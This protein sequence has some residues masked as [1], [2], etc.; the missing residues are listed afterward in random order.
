MTAKVAPPLWL[1]AFYDTTCQLKSRYGVVLLALDDLVN[2]GD[3]RLVVTLVDDQSQIRI[4]QGPYLQAQISLPQ[5]ASS[6]CTFYMDESI[7]GELHPTAHY[8]PTHARLV[9]LDIDVDV[10]L[11]VPKV[12]LEQCS[13]TIH[14]YLLQ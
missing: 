1:D 3:G 8:E 14:R 6:L 13:S 4:F 10:V 11:F 5:L 9:H 12:L 7:P 2:D